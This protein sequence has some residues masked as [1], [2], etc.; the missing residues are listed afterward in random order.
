MD[1][2]D[3]HDQH[4]ANVERQFEAGGGASDDRLSQQPLSL[5]FDDQE[6]AEYLAQVFDYDWNRT[7]YRSSDKEATAG[8][9][10]R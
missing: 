6:I 10:R 2:R 9:A 5:I 1:Q 3:Q 8:C 7:R 4:D